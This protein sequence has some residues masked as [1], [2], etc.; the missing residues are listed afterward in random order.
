MV[1]EIICCKAGLARVIQSTKSLRLN[2]WLSVEAD[3]S[4]NRALGVI[5]VSGKASHNDK[6][7]YMLRLFGE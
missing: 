2:S 7:F 6:V 4:R 5:G 3:P 1:A